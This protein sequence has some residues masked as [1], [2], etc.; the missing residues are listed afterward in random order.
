MQDTIF[1]VGHRNPDTDSVCSAIAYAY[2]RNALGDSGIRPARAGEVNAE[3]A[4]V[5]ERFGLPSPALLTDAAGLD[6]I[7]VDH[8]ETAQAL[9]HIEQASIHEI[10]EHHRLGD[11]HLREPIF[12]HFEPVGATATLIGEQYFLRGVE[13][14]PAMAGILI[15]SILSDT[16]GFS[17]PTTTGKDRSVVARLL[18]AASLDVDALAAQL[19]AIRTGDIGTVGAAE[20]LQRDFKEFR[21]GALRVGIAQVEVTQPGALAA[22]AEELRRAMQA[23]RARLGLGE[24]ILMVTD[25][26][27]KASE[28]WTVGEPLELVEAAFGPSSGG[29]VHVPGCVSRKKQVVP[30]LESAAT[31]LGAPTG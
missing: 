2:L 19:L 16:L 29:V 15:A 21:I 17:S 9:P 8:N 27:A 14:P 22:R 4:F 12:I 30:Q 11:L 20:L 23:L 6:L 3:T 5:L 25:V 18:P 26:N 13:P 31:R 1:V 24:L 7:L 28:L 10:W